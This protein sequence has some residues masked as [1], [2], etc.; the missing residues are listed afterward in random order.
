MQNRKS[1]LINR[2]YNVYVYE[3]CSREFPN[4]GW[5]KITLSLGFY[6]HLPK[7]VLEIL[8]SAAILVNKRFPFYEISDVRFTPFPAPHVEQWSENKNPVIVTW[9]QADRR[10]LG[11]TIGLPA[12]E[13]SRIV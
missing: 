9:Q 1:L 11:S 12:Y 7:E 4:Y 3:I 6:V 10:F 8:L 2:R 5:Q 13:K